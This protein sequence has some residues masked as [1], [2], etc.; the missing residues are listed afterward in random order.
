MAFINNLIKSLPNGPRIKQ[1]VKH[2]TQTQG[3][4]AA[5]HKLKYMY[6]ISVTS[7]FLKQLGWFACV[8]T[9]FL[10]L[11]AFALFDIQEKQ[12]LLS[13]LVLIVSQTVAK[14]TGLSLFCRGFL[15]KQWH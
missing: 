12:N 10:E 8:Q 7:Q 14:A 11:I 5:V 1:T 6:E 9:F 13:V 15:V 2:A 3:E 4:R